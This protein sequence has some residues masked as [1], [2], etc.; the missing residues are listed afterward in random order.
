MSRSVAK[1]VMIYKD[2]NGRS[3]LLW[4]ETYKKGDKVEILKHLKE[5]ARVQEESKIKKAIDSFEQWRKD[6]GFVV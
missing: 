5:M 1:P 4:P 6:P 2:K 3:C